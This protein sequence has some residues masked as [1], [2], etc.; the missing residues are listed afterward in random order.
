MV[1]GWWRPTTGRVSRHVTIHLAT[2][3]HLNEKN[4]IVS[5]MVAT[6]LLLGF[7]EMFDIADRKRRREEE[8]A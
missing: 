7:S 2:R 6:S 5:V 8:S 1:S 3:G 4:A